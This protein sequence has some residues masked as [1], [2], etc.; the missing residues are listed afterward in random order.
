MYKKNATFAK[1]QMMINQTNKTHYAILLPFP[2]FLLSPRNKY[3]L[4]S[5]NTHFVPSSTKYVYFFSVFN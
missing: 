2:P 1:K 3:P 4:Q 5:A